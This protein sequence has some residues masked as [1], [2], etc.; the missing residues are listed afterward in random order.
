MALQHTCFDLECNE[1]LGNYIMHGHCK[2]PILFKA[3]LSLKLRPTGP[4]CHQ[5]THHTQCLHKA[6]SIVDF[7][8]MVIKLLKWSVFSPHLSL[9]PQTEI[10]IEC[11]QKL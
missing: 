11:L 7:V 2:L 8:R 1:L 4:T 5:L 9:G 6:S 3:Y 10:M